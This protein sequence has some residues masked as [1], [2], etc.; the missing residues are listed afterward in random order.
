[1]IFGHKSSDIASLII[2]KEPLINAWLAIIAAN[3]AIVTP[4]N[5]NHP[6]MIE[7]NGLIS[8]TILSG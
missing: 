6:G 1:L 3:V 5:E 2:V 4:M 8:V 7:K